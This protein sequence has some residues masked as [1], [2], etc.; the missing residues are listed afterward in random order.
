MNE[1]NPAIFLESLTHRYGQRTALSDLSLSI[2]PNR[3]FGLLGPNGGGKTTLFRILATLLRP[4]Q[5]RAEIFGVDVIKH[6]AQIRQMVGIV[7]QSSS[8]DPKLTVAENLTH[9]GH[10]YGLYGK[11]LTTL[12]DSLLESLRLTDRAKELTESLSGGLKRRVEIAKALLSQ[13]RVLL[14]DEPSTGLDPAARIDL[15]NLVQNVRSQH[16]LTVLFTTHLMEEADKA[17]EIA[18]LSQGSLVAKGEPFALREALG[19]NVLRIDA[20]EPE[21]LA[22]ILKQ[23]LGLLPSLVDGELRMESNDALSLANQI[24]N[25]YA[26]QIRTLSIARPTLEDVF[27]AKTGLHF[28]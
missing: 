11:K 23:E 5:G 3:F 18:I 20:I 15:W 19:Q 27:V 17:D 9:A 2:P 10:L 16:Q 26:S 4:T 25:Q 14:M 7:F 8:I 28:D 21:T 24:G 13:P 6:P 12:V 1:Q 22:K